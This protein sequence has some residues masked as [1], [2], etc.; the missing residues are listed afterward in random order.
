MLEAEDRVHEARH[1][2]RH[3]EILRCASSRARRRHPAGA[4]LAAIDGEGAR[5]RLRMTDGDRSRSRRGAARRPAREPTT[6]L[7]RGRGAC[8]RG[9]HPGRRGR[10]HRRPDVFAIGD[11]ARFSERALRPRAPAGMR[12]ERHRSGQGRGRRDLGKPKISYDPVPWFWSDQYEFKLQIAGLFDGYDAGRNRRR[13][14]ERAI[15]RRIPQGRQADR[16]R[17]RQRRPRPH[18]GAA[19]DRRGDQGC[20]RSRRVRLARR[21]CEPNDA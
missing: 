8:L 4:R 12:A 11:C 16:G 14:G 10:P 3:S 1:R 15:L 21:K 18:A 7:A 5:C 17:C 6:N 13:S 2:A 9:R 20:C 19:P